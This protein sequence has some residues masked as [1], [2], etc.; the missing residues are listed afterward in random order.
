MSGSNHLS[1]ED[2]DRMPSYA[3]SSF[4]Q[5]S[6]L[7]PHSTNDP[8]DNCATLS[9]MHGSWCGPVRDGGV[10]TS[11]ARNVKTVLETRPSVLHAD[12]I[13][14]KKDQT[15][16]R[17]LLL[18]LLRQKVPVQVAFLQGA[19]PLQTESIFPRLLQLLTTCPLWSINLG[20][21][22]FSE[23]QCEKLAEALRQS[24]V[25]HMFYE[26]T[27]AGQW[28]EE[29]RSIIRANRAKHALWRL[30]PDVEQ[31]R[32][33]LSAVKSWFAPLSHSVNKQWVT[34]FHEGWSDVERVQCEACGKWRRL[35]ASLDG[36]PGLF[37]CALNTWDAR[38]ASCEVAEEQWSSEMPMNGDE[39]VCQVRAP[40][41]LPCVRPRLSPRRHAP[42]AMRPSPRARRH[43]PCRVRPPAWR[44]PPCAPHRHP[45]PLPPPPR[46]RAA[47]ATECVA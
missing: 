47:A 9:L 4:C 25:T 46:S 5:Q 35:P 7:P 26:C 37:Y 2:L 40:T 23:E 38:L 8:D 11:C 3:H 30:G 17:Y 10:P 31:N 36:W 18:E 14:N 19:V 22:R 20:E 45:V 16:V 32:V 44:Q 13:I 43:A 24:G 6:T 21:L 27:V 28:K 12:E 1:A 33:V 41:D 42:V 15:Q 39:V 34:R 29:F